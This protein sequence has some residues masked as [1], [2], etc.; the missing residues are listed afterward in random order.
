MQPHRRIPFRGAR[1]VEEEQDSDGMEEAMASLLTN[2]AKLKKLRKAKEKKAKRRRRA[3]R[4]N[5]AQAMESS[6]SSSDDVPQYYPGDL[7]DVE[8]EGVWP[9]KTCLSS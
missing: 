6:D 9:V 2:K 8:V 5:A 1:Q 4:P 7:V 3:A